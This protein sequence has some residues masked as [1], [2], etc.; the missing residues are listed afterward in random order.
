M[1]LKTAFLNQELVEVENYV[2]SWNLFIC[3]GCLLCR[4]DCLIK[5]WALALVEDPTTW[6]HFPWGAYYFQ[7]I[8]DY[9]KDAGPNEGQNTYRL[10]GPLWAVYFWALEI[11]PSLQCLA[12]IK[13]AILNYW[14][15]WGGN[16]LH[17]STNVVLYLIK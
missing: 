11:F 14:D 5:D 1:D 6:H 4:E 10:S 13:L 2:K 15:V 17:E 12:E 7:I 3:Y 8:D 9:M 16:R